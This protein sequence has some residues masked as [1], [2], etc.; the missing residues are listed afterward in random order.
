MKRTTRT[1]YDSSTLQASVHVAIASAFGFRSTTFDT[2]WD[3]DF[4]RVTARTARLRGRNV[5]VLDAIGRKSAA[6]ASAHKDWNKA[7][8]RKWAYTRMQRIGIA[9]KGLTKTRVKTSAKGASTIT[10][11]QNKPRCENTCWPS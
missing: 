1:C 11:D 9:S 8:R 7:R 6:A 4:H 3:A 10:L 2:F 5:P